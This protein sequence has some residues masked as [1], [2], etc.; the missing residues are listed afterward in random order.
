MVIRLPSKHERKL[1]E[2]ALSCKE[3]GDQLILVMDE[4]KPSERQNGIESFRKALSG[5]KKMGKARDVE[6][7][8]KKMQDQ[9]GLYL[10]A[11]MK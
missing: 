9:L 8:L 2:L 1:Q 3:L 7:R 10:L 11:I 6:R 4:L 5:R